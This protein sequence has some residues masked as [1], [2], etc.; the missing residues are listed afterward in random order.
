MS[1]GLFWRTLSS[2]MYG[3][4]SF[5]A[6]ACDIAILVTITTVVRRHRPDAYRGLQSWAIVSLVG[7][8]VT[9][10]ART[11]LP[12]FASSDGMEGFFR[13]SVLLTFVSIGLHIV[14]VVM[15]VRGLTALAQP[16]RPIVVEGLP[17][18]R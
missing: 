3:G 15:L 17:P 11:V 2:W 9:T 1:E 8:V 13:T 7:F 18:Y 12:H 10:I 14:L 16:P 4:S 5:V 6:F